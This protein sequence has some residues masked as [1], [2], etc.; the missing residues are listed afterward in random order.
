MSSLKNF[1][2]FVHMMNVEDCEFDFLVELEKMFVNY[3][4]Y[5]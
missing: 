1:E 5:D 4:C 2:I 3:L